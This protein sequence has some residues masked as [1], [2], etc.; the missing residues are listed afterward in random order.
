MIMQ[1]QFTPLHHGAMRGNSEVVSILLMAN[2]DVNKKAKVSWK[3][4]NL[5]IINV[6]L[7]INN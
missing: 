7:Y 4:N 1:Q 2:A 6:Y 3:L 5:L